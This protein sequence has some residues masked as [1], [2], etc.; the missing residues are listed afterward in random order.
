VSDH[1]DHLHLVCLG[2]SAVIESDVHEADDFA[3]NLLARHGFV[4]DVRHMAIHGWCAQC[5]TQR[6]Q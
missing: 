2:C 1:A 3:G 5:S 6:Q 4:A